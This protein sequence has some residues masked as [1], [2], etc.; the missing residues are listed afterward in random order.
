MNPIEQ[1]R[2]WS[3][4]LEGG[5]PPRL[6]RWSVEQFGPRLAVG[7]SFGRDGLVVLDITRAIAPNIPVLFLETGYHFPETLQFRDQLKAAW[8]LN[9][10]DVRPDLSVAEQDDRF[11]PRLYARDPDACC[12]MRKVEPLQKALGGYSAWITGVRRDQNSGRAETPV[13]EWQ[14][15]S[16][17]RGV[18]KINPMVA[19]SRSDV[20]TYLSDHGIPAHPLWARG[21]PSVGCAPCTT[22]VEPGAAERSGRWASSGKTECGI[23]VVGV[24]RAPPHGAP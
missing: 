5:D 1:A 22:P 6:I 17:G 2:V 3:D 9:V 18:Y 11:G 4:S 12:R 21:Y 19:W 15:L 23:H 24:Q 7:S 10:V 20:D 16:P 14:E 8:H 13:V